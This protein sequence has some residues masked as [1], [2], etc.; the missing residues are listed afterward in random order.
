MRFDIVSI[1]GS[2]R[3]IERSISPEIFISEKHR[4][5]KFLLNNY[6]KYLDYISNTFDRDLLDGIVKC[7]TV[8]REN[9]V[10]CEIIAYDDKEIYE[11]EGYEIKFLGIDITYDL[12]ES[13]IYEN[14][15]FPRLELLNENQL[16][17]EQND[18]MEIIK[19][20]SNNDIE[21]MPC[22]VYKIQV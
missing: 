6:I 21:W 5:F 3:G 10:R 1:T 11:I 14:K 9:D 15:N 17:E 8:F 18:A 7:Y 22:W 16:F 4:K 12:A 20:T 13:M 19:L 2:Y